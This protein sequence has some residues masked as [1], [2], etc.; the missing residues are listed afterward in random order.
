MCSKSSLDNEALS[1]LVNIQLLK[2]GLVFSATS[3]V[4]SYHVNRQSDNSLILEILSL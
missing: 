2:L 4:V 1:N 3:G